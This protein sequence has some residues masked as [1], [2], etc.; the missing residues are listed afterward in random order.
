MTIPAYKTLYKIDKNNN[1]SEWSIKIIPLK[2]MYN[3]ITTHGIKDGK[4]I[5]H[6][7]F[8]EEGKAKR[9]VLEQAILFTSKKWNDKKE[10]ELYVE[11]IEELESKS[12]SNSII[13]RPMLAKKF[14]FDLYTNAKSRSFRIPFPAYIQMKYDGIRCI[15]YLKN[16]NVVLES[17]QGIEFTH[18]PDLKASLKKVLA[19]LPSTFYFDGEL[20]CQ[21]L[22]FEVVSGLIR[23]KDLKPADIEYVN[24]IEYYIYDCIDTVRLNLT[25]SER[26]S[27]LKDIFKKPIAK[28]VLADTILV[29]DVNQVKT[30]HDKFVSEGFEGIM[31][32][33]ASGI[34]DIDKRSKYLQ[35]YKEFME[36]EFKI[37]GFHDGTGDEKNL[38]L[39]DCITKDGKPFA[40]RPKGTFEYRR[41]LFDE[42]AKYIGKKLTV[43]FQEYSADGIPR[44]P[45]GKAI[46][47]IY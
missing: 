28:C 20:Y 30:Y 8:I 18:F 16:G 21:T 41:K 22:N 38:V 34:Y 27:I 14:E 1:I 4:K 36:E 26:S 25:F 11:D 32:R 13:V 47:D 24:M 17:R 10:K 2:A 15:S 43:I 39:W 44:F 40:V 37:V 6:E 35:K 31:V 3:V 42:G 23:L 19:K 33:D 5:M 7:H 9:T 46:R 45:V 12:N 29:N